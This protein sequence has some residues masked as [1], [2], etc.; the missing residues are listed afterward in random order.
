MDIT[1][2]CP[3][4]GQELE[5]DAD[6]A[7][8]EINCPTCGKPLVIP[9]PTQ[10]TPGRAALGASSGATPHE[11]PGTASAGGGVINPIAASAAAKEEKHF[12]VPI[13]DKP[14]ESL[15][16]K[17]PK[18]LEFSAKETEKKIRVK[19]IRHIDCIEVGHDKFD[20]R[21]TQFLQQIGEG[22]LISITPITYTYLDIATQKLI[23]DF[24]V[25]IVFRG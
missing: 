17:P 25:M 13:R 20:E 14:A 6:A 16:S 22:N 7:G 5:A 3:H 11:K 18:P 10:S 1:F 9:Q 15:I 12:Q 24:G 2:T 21:V 4:C 19:T 8:S 23:T